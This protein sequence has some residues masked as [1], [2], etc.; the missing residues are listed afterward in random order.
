MGWG[1]MRR[2]PCVSGLT[3][4]A[5]TACAATPTAP[6]PAPPPT[7]PAAQASARADLAALERKLKPQATTQLQVHQWLGAPQAVGASV[8]ANGGRY[9]EWVY[10]FNGANETATHSRLEL[11]FDRR[12]VLRGYRWYEPR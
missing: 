2:R 9:E 4:L 11:R 3:A 8:E 6:E 1:I 12:G 7:T 10:Y 5:L